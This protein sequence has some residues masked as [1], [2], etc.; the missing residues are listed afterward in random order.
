MK[1]I[2]QLLSKE[3]QLIY[4]TKNSFELSNKGI[5]IIKNLSINMKRFSKSMILIEGHC[6]SEGSNLYNQNLSEKRAEEVKKQLTKIGIEGNRIKT[7]GY[8][9]TNPLYSNDTEDERKM[10]RRIKFVLVK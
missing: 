9:E 3:N 8:G 6:S 7:K 4:F 1:D 10:N 5:S 2:V